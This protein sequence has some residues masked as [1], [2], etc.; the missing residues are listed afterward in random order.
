MVQ[1]GEAVLGSSLS[2]GN[3]TSGT[4]ADGPAVVLDAGSA[5]GGTLIVPGG[6]FLL[7]AEYVREG[8]DLSLVGS[9]GAEV[10]VVD[11]FAVAD[12]PVLESDSG[13]RIL[14][15]VA[16]K[17]AGPMAP[18]Q[19]AQAAPGVAGEPVARVETID[20]EAF[21]VR[22]DGTRVALTE[23][24]PIFQGDVLET[25]PGAALGLVY[26]D[27]M[28][29]GLDENTRMVIDQVFYDPTANQGTALFSLVEGAFLMLSGEIA[30]LGEDVVQIQTPTGVIGIR[31]TNLA[32]SHISV[33]QVVL[34][35]NPDD[36]VGALSF[37]NDGGSVILDQAFEGLTSSSF[38]LAPSQP[39]IFA[40]AE[41]AMTSLGISPKAGDTC[42]AAV[43]PSTTWRW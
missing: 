31:G 28:T 21:A 39:T 16:E 5:E 36:T 11:F 41:A 38:S 24:S 25:G 13:L 43:S 14:P 33:T 7:H 18:G 22:A 1:G 30:K 4:R 42:D 32:A 15:Q 35:P 20:G 12:A 37:V 29:M 26:I 6:E 9:D 27:G 3:E 17:L 10:L 34:L 23:G 40:S 8:P 2:Q 19:Y